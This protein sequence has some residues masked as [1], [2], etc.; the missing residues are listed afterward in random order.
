[1]AAQL[2][3]LVKS[4]PLFRH[5]SGAVVRGLIGV[6]DRTEERNDDDEAYE[7]VRGRRSVV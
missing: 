4:L 6:E 3:L 1:M 5:G 7:I 2:G